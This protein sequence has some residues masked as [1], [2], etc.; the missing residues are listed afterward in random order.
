MS[1]VFTPACY[2]HSSSPSHVC[3]NMGGRGFWSKCFGTFKEDMKISV[4]GAQS[5]LD[6]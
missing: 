3:M 6:I 4:K 1:L 2:F 5:K